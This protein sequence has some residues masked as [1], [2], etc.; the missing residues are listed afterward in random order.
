MSCAFIFYLKKPTI[1]EWLES[2]KEFRDALAHRIPLYVPLYRLTRKEA[3]TWRDLFTQ[4]KNA[5][6]QGNLEDARRFEAE[7]DK[8]GHFYPRMTH[9]Y[10]DNAEHVLFH[11]QILLDWE[12]VME[13][14]DEFSKTFCT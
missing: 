4:Q 13:L 5:L 2:L 8:L 11:P 1:S 7:R 14:A 9:S 3:E 6:L 12:F 10:E